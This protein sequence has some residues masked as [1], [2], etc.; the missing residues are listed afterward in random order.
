MI[1]QNKGKEIEQEQDT[2]EEKK[3]RKERKRNGHR[4]IAYIN[5]LFYLGISSF[6]HIHA[7]PTLSKLNPESV[8]NVLLVQQEAFICIDLET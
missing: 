5:L 2:G 1:H 3:K 8:Y 7:P 4:K 6:V